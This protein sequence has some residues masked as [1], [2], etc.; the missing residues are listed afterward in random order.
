MSKLYQYNGK[1]WIEIAKNGLDG[2]DYILTE[3]DKKEIAEYI[4]VPEPVTGKD[5]KD[6][7]PDTPDQVIEKIHTSKKLIKKEKI[8]G[9]DDLEAKLQIIANRPQVQG[10]GGGAS[11][12]RDIRAGTNVTV[13]KNNE[14]YTISASG[15]AATDEL[16]KLNASDPT[17]GYLDDKITGYG[18]LTAESDTLDTVT[19]R[20]AITTNDITVADVVKT[21]SGTITRDGN[22]Y[23]SSITKTGGRTIT[24][25]RDGD[26]YISSFT[27]STNTWTITRTGGLIS[28][29]S[30][31]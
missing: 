4:K 10:V 16:V 7:S 11:G 30:V 19:D 8:E 2:S 21:R 9:I 13:S 15:G 29:W 26:N 6:G 1:E 18:F 31:A 25:T 5:G 12:V 24:F 14:V 27:D 3:D 28:S 23:I 17:A 20:G 22:G